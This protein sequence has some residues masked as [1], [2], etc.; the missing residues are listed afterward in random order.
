MS[1]VEEQKDAQGKRNGAAPILTG[2]EEGESASQTDLAVT[3]KSSPG[4]ANPSLRAASRP[5][6]HKGLWIPSKCQP[7][8]KPPGVSELQVTRLEAPGST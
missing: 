5:F 8:Y 4:L 2:G 1:S 7:C 6:L 3:T